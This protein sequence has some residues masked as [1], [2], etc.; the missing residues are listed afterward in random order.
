ME[1]RYTKRLGLV[2]VI[3][4]WVGAGGEYV[5]WVEG[6]DAAVWAKAGEGC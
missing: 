6:Y 2:G 5:D 4:G 3:K 1:D